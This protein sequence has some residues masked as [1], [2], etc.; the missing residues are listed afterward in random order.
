MHVPL[1]VK[2][3]I[4]LFTKLFLGR[5][6]CQSDTLTLLFVEKSLL[7]FVTAEALVQCSSVF[8]VLHTELYLGMR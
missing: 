1:N 7:N 8:I 3:G 2:K 6:P 4:I 5:Q